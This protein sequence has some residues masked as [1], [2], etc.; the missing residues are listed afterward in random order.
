MGEQSSVGGW[1]KEGREVGVG[2][3][4]NEKHCVTE[5]PQIPQPAA[6]LVSDGD[7]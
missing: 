2:A 3:G 1:S 4:G 7:G 6:D 5:I